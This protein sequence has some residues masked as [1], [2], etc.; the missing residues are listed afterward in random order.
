MISSISLN[1]MLGD[2]S[3]ATAKSR[4]FVRVFGLAFGIFANNGLHVLILEVLLKY[5]FFDFGFVLSYAGQTT[6]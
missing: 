6:S 5:P 1:A 4:R 3:L 2:L